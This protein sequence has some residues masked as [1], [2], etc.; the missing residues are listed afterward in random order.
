M[1]GGGGG[2]GLQRRYEANMKKGGREGDGFFC[3]DSRRNRGGE[4]KIRVLERTK[5]EGEQ[6]KG[7]GSMGSSQRAAEETGKQN[8][9]DR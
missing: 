9:K 8:E 4:T 1:G 3:T 6:G 5:E 2:G 7:G